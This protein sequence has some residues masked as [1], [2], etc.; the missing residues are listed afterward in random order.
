MRKRFLATLLALAMVVSVTPFAL[1]EESSQLPAVDGNGVITLTEDVTIDSLTLETGETI[2]D[3]NGH[4]LTC[5][6]R[7]GLEIGE[8]QTLTFKDTSVSGADRGGTLAFTGVQSTTAAIAP[9][10]GGTVNVSNLTV[11]CSGSA[12]SRRGMRQL[13]ISQIVM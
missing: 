1:A 12:F 9:E 7:Q 6:W 3:L 10:K 4:N 2:I 11:T 5:T 13:L 8:G